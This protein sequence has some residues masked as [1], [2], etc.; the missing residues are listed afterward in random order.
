[1]AA[2]KVRPWDGL[3]SGP[4]PTH[5]LMDRVERDGHRL[6]VEA[7]GRQQTKRG[8]TRCLDGRE[9]IKKNRRRRTA[10]RP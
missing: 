8:R 6:K 1:M 9:A 4:R 5:R 3:L 2:E 7:T 10:V